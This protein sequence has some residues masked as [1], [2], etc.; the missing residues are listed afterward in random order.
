M[1]WEAGMQDFTPVLQL[2]KFRSR[3]KMSSPRFTHN[4]HQSY[5]IQG[6]YL[7]DHIIPQITQAFGDI[8]SEEYRKQ[9]HKSKDNWKDKIDKVIRQNQIQEKKASK[10]AFFH[11]KLYPEC[12]PLIRKINIIHQKEFLRARLEAWSKNEIVCE[13]GIEVSSPTSHIFFECENEEI[14]THKSALWVLVELLAP[15]NIQ[16]STKITKILWLLGKNSER[17]GQHNHQQLLSS[18]AAELIYIASKLFTLKS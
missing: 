6:N 13:C 9:I 11:I 4:K 16:Q 15:E 3:H 17:T 14:T 12:W 5:Y 1:L 7:Y 10:N 18:N 8:E 2:A